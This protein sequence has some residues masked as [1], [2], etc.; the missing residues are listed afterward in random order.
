MIYE[1][2]IIEPQE[3]LDITLNV[4]APMTK[5]TARKLSEITLAMQAG[6]KVRQVQPGETVWWRDLPSTAPKAKTRQAEAN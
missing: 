6:I 1:G 2:T 5:D 3:T 4:A